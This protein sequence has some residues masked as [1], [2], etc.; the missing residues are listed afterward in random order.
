M[1]IKEEEADCNATCKDDQC[2]PICMYIKLMYKATPNTEKC[3]YCRDEEELYRRQ[4][5]LLG[6]R[7]KTNQM[8]A[9]FSTSPTNR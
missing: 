8:A 2:M 1:P 3:V 9:S 7:F 5:M 6:I 4:D